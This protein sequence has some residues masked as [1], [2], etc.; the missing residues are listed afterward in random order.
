MTNLNDEIYGVLDNNLC[1]LACRLVQDDTKVVLPKG[2]FCFHHI[3]FNAP[4]RGRYES[5]QKRFGW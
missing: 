2:Q 3:T 1:D 5:D 4:W